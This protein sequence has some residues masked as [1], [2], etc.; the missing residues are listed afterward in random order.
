MMRKLKLWTS[1]V[2]VIGLIGA[3][4][5]GWW[6]LDLRHRPT[7]VRKNAAEIAR[8]LEQSGWVSPHVAGTKKIY[9]IS[10]RD[11]PNCAAYKQSEFP[12]LQK[13][14]VD[15]RVIV[16]PMPNFDGQTHASPAELST[17][18]ELW[19][20]RSWPLYEQWMK[21]P[22][23]EWTAPNIIPANGDITRTG[24][25]DLSRKT[26]DELA[27]LLKPNG[28]ELTWP[29]LI[30]WDAKGVMR[31]HAGPAEPGIRK[32]RNELGA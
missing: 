12:R 27:R 7:A 29:T 2:L 28:V 3:G 6:A 1:L 30:W 21:T 15:T 20:N 18:A 9:M 5:Y 14:G 23:A 32:I 26:I 25:V 24:V 10:F 11:C 13:A 19:V 16:A 4:L 17:V 31:V 22:S 8:L